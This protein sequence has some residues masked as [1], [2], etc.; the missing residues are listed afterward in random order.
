MRYPD[1]VLGYADEL[2]DEN[3][4]AGVMDTLGNRFPSG[5]GFIVTP[6]NVNLNTPLP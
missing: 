2:E 4:L 6:G 1:W 5:P 3:V